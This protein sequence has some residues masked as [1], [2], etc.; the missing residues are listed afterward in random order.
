MR[1]SWE[2]VEEELNALIRLNINSSGKKRKEYEIDLRDIH[3][4][5][6]K[7]FFIEQEKNKEIIKRM[8]HAIRTECGETKK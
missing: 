4:T 3:A 8:M 5:I 1:N 7:G 2:T 6:T